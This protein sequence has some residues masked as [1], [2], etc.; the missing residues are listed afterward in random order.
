MNELDALQTPI[1]ATPNTDPMQ[2]IT[3]PSSLQMGNDPL[4]GQPN[5][6]PQPPSTLPQMGQGQP[7]SAP[8]PDD[9]LTALATQPSDLMLQA[10]AVHHARGADTLNS[11]SK[12]LVGDTAMRITRNSDGSYSAVPQETTPGQRWGRIAAIALAGAAKGFG[13]GQ[14]PGGMGRAASAGLDV[15]MQAQQMQQD[16]TMKLASDMNKQDRDRLLFN[17]NMAMMDQNLIS[18]RFKNQ[19]D[20]VKFGLDV[21]DN[22]LKN[23]QTLRENGAQFAG[24]YGSLAE[25]YAAAKDP[26]SVQAHTG[27]NGIYIPITTFDKD[28]VPNGIDGFI[29]PEDARKKL[30]TSRIEIPTKKPDPKDPTKLIDGDPIVHEPGT[31]TGEDLATEIKNEHLNENNLTMT[32]FQA[33]LRQREVVVAEKKAPAEIAKDYAQAGKDAADKAAANVGTWSL[34][35]DRNGN[36]IWANNKTLETRPANGVE[37]VGTAAKAQTALD[38]KYGGM[39][40]AVNFANGYL[41]AVANDPSKATGSDD[42]ALQEQYFNMTRTDKG[43]RLNQPLL[44]RLNDSQPWIGSMK[45]K[46]YHAL[47][48]SWFSPEQRQQIVN[49]M[50]TVAQENGLDEHGN[51]TP[52]ADAV[53]HPAVEP[54]APGGGG[55]GAPPTGAIPYYQNGKLVGYYPDAS[56]KP[57]TYVDLTKGQ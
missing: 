27:Q 55:G 2:Y 34:Q 26:N 44:N 10:A 54:P 25:M 3:Q 43:F 51:Y 20:K 33:G 31:I 7:S 14:G 38:N 19:T 46:A 37:H 52:N 28:G 15:G 11:I 9:R 12:A 47:Y 6:G 16:N 30:N 50:N 35:E 48:G 41:A 18:A 1:V 17:A 23:A 29:L 49:T 21:Q 32:G 57:G 13:A 22:L 40:K 42:E 39:K 53:M 24:H 5:A 4:S 56:K 36:S 8:M 45:S